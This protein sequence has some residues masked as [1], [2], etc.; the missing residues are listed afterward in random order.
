MFET[1]RPMS[2]GEKLRRLNW[3][4]LALVTALAA[5]GVATLTS[6]AGGSFAPWAERHTLRCIAG[7]AIV[8]GCAL[9]PVRYW[10]ALAIPAYVA[11]LGLLAAVPFAGVEALGAKR[12][13][14]A[15]GLSLQPS[16][17]MKVALVLVLARFYAAVPPRAVSQP[18][19][20]ALPLVLIAVPVALTLRQPDLGTAVLFA[21]LGLGLMF[22]AGTSL[23]YFA[24]G[25]MAALLVLPLAVSRLHDYQRRRLE[26]F[27]D[28]ASDPQGAGYHI[29]QARIALGN[30]GWSGQGYLQGT[31]SQLDFVPEKMTDFIFV[32]IGEEWGFMGA[33][34]VLGLYAA[35]ISVLFAMALSARAMPSRLLIAGAALSLSVYV[36][37]NVAMVTG[38]V[39]VVGV[40][41]PLIS[42]GGTSMLTLMIALGLAM[43]AHVHS[44]EARA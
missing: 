26:I 27:L 13:L 9:V 11:A 18:H 37:I 16:E 4:A 28:P 40:P 8:A 29:T 36:T 31:Q 3:A 33:A 14:N 22:L 24:G 43:S 38:L 35:L 7:L 17:I 21:G 2:I 44:D 41:L 32:M 34:A 5:I 30:G 25:A 15:G 6:V 23:W 1:L 39:P 12:W 19:V 10:L 42:Y 20:V